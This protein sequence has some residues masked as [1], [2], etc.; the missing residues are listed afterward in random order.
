MP[1]LDKIKRRIKIVET[2]SKIT[3]AMK[4]VATVKIKKAMEHFKSVNNFCNEFYAIID[5]LIKSADQKIIFSKISK[6]TSKL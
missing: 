1:S 3:G 5:D 4:L 2:T 6:N